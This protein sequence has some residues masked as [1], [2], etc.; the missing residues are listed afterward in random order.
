MN[1][2]INTK[3]ADIIYGNDLTT[4]AEVIGMIMLE[5]ARSPASLDPSASVDRSIDMVCEEQFG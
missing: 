2:N 5:L 1:V 3:I 4:A